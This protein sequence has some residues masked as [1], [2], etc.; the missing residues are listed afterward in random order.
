MKRNGHRFIAVKG[1][2]YAHCSICGSWVIAPKCNGANKNEIFYEINGR[3]CRDYIHA[4]SCA[5]VITE[6]IMES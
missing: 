1:D 6:Q 2:R 5:E 4:K 3:F